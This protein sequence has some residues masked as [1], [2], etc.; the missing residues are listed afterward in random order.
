MRPA[1]VAFVLVFAHA[2]LGA[3]NPAATK[4][5]AAFEV[6]SVRRNVSGDLR[7][8]SDREPGGRVTAI[9]VTLRDL[10]R[11]AYRLHD[12]QL[13]GGPEWFDR[14]HFDVTGKAPA[15]AS[16][17]EH[18]AMMRG[19]LIE[20]FSL[21][22]HWEQRELPVYEL[23]L[24]RGDGRLG[25]GLR[26]RPD[27]AIG[28]RRESDKAPCG[29][30]LFGPGRLTVRGQPLPGFARDRIVIDKT[31]LTGN[32]DIDLEYTPDPGEF[33]PIGPPPPA[34]AP[35]LPTALEEQL[36]LRLRPA[37][38]MVDVLVVDRA[39]PLA[40]QLAFDIV[41]VKR[42]PPEERPS[43][44]GIR[45]MPGGRLQAPSVTV[46]QLI[47]AAYELQDCRLSIR[48]DG[49]HRTASTSRQARQPASTRPRR[50]PCC[51][52]CWPSVSVSSRIP[53]RASCPS[54]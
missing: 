54:T 42:R 17:A 52:P 15:G 21:R 35:S 41:S 16:D 37:R 25:P 1:V 5:T 34:N 53:K 45:L 44:G 32:F 6:A 24:A 27:C 11:G 49:R 30:A 36:G 33:P 50:A 19:L 26:P 14:D 47:A 29:G 43:G 20:R 51:V 9:N 39:E 4:S 8:S 3:Q 40:E 46:R 31:G 38:A 22:V 28:E 23:V 2:T 18:G 48:S 13:V 10:V 12:Q 7:Q